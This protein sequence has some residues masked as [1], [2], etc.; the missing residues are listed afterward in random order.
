MRHDHA[1]PILAD[2]SRRLAI[3][4]FVAGNAAPL[5]LKS[6]LISPV[7]RRVPLDLVVVPVLTGGTVTGLSIHAG[8]WTS[9]ALN[10]PPRSVPVLR[11]RL[12][13]SEQKFGFDPTGHTGKALT[14]AIATLPHD[15][16]VA[17]GAAAMEELALTAMSLADRPRPKLVLTPSPLGRHLYAFVWLPRD[18][19]TTARRTAIA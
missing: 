19:L 8:L 3:D 11:Q 12:A 14:H 6:S 13:A 5:L 15:V 7:H 1:V 2:R 18:E 10:A 9:A 17:V 16:M 4:Y